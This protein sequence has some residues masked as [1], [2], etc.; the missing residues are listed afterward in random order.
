MPGPLAPLNDARRLRLVEINKT[1]GR[2]AAIFDKAEGENIHARPPSHVR[3][4]TA[5]MGDRVRKARAIH[6]NAQ[7]MRFGDIAER[8]DLGRRINPTIFRRVGDGQSVGLRP[9]HTARRCRQPCRERIRRQLG[10]V[11]LNQGELGPMGVK[12]RRAA[13]IVLNVRVPVAQH[14]AIGRAEACQR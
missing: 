8:R 11:P 13:F 10:A 14:T 3:R 7:S 12:F 2:H 1:F 5:Q 6:V 9:V 4:R